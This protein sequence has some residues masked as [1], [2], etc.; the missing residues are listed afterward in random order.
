MKHGA[1]SRREENK[2]KSNLFTIQRRKKTKALKN[3]TEWKKIH[4][5]YTGNGKVNRIQDE[6]S[7]AEEKT[8]LN[9]KSDEEEGK[10]AI[11]FSFL[12]SKR[13]KESNRENRSLC[14]IVWF[15][16][17]NAYMCIIY[18]CVVLVWFYQFIKISM[19]GMRALF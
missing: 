7:K 8:T 4:A 1:K 19:H 11:F 2:K 12:F 3:R 9:L 17:A 5:N 6:E 10:K 16:N 13:I 14:A 15:S 18:M